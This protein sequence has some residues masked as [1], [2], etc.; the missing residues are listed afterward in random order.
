M[1]PESNKLAVYFIFFV[2]GAYVCRLSC[3]HFWVAWRWHAVS[4]C[5]ELFSLFF[6]IFLVSFDMATNKHTAEYKAS[7]QSIIGVGRHRAVGIT[8]PPFCPCVF[9]CKSPCFTR[10]TYTVLYKYIYAYLVDISRES[11]QSSSRLRV[12]IYPVDTDTTSWLVS[13]G[14]F[15]LAQSFESLNQSSILNFFL[16]VIYISTH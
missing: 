15:V 14:I 9:V 5:V 16:D 7:V 1:P 11:L 4:V 8:E 10:V 3:T 2:P 6:Y 13:P 12:Y